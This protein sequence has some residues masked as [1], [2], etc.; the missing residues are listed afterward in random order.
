MGSVWSTKEVQTMTVITIS[1]VAGSAGDEVARR[2]CELLDYHYFD[3]TLM[4]QVAQEMGISETEVVDFSEDSYK[5][6]S[7]VNALLRRSAHV[8]TASTWTSTASGEETRVGASLDEET[9]AR[10]E[11][12]IVHGLR[13][14][15]N[16]VV[17][18]RGGQAVLR[19][20]PGVLHV[21]IIAGREDRVPRLMEQHRLTR[22][23]AIDMMGERDHATAEYLKRFHNIDWADPLLYHLILN[24]SKLGVEGAAQVI[25]TATHNME[26]QL[27]R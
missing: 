16:I 7:F 17:V 1:R 3:K 2:V 21:R 26:A 8:S 10:F 22:S 14:Q 15:G 20:E 19:E 5:M 24:T 11:A 9:A 27:K 23:A 18:G 4:S 13:E 25:V 12:T 6:R